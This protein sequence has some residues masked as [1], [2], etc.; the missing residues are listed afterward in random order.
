MNLGDTQ[1][2]VDHYPVTWLR[3]LEEGDVQNNYNQDYINE[4]GKQNPPVWFKEL[5]EK[6]E[7]VVRQL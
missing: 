3:H 6:D 4:V 7:A 5:S 2:G 1:N